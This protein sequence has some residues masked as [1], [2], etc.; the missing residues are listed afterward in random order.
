LPEQLPFREACFTHPVGF[1][2]L[3]LNFQL[4]VQV[5]M[6]QTGHGDVP[7]VV[8]A[9]GCLCCAPG[10]LVVL[11]LNKSVLPFVECGLVSS[12]AYLL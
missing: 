9:T 2:V 3:N 5:V 4:Q 1:E 12:E 8:I 7:M 6:A 10:R 11:G